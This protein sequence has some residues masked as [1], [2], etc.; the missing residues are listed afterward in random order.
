MATVRARH[1]STRTGLAEPVNTP[2]SLQEEIERTAYDLYE[3]RG[4]I[5]GH[6]WED[7]LEAE[8]MVKQREEAG[9]R[10]G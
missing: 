5:D 4:R 9:I 8:R 7:W 2:G 1:Q 6:D 10:S 3:Q